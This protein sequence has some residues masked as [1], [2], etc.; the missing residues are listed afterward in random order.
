MAARGIRRGVGRLPRF[1][2]WTALIILAALVVATLA[3]RRSMVRHWAA[4]LTYIVFSLG[5]LAAGRVALGGPILALETRYLAD[6]TIPLTL[7]VGAAL[8][9]LKDEQRP[10]LPFADRVRQQWSAQQRIAG[11]L[12]A[13]GVVLVLSLHAMNSYAALSSANPY[14]PF[15]TN[16][17][18]SLREL[19]EGAEI[20]DTALPVDI[21]GPIFQEYNLVSRFI[22]PQLTQDQRTTLA[23]RREFRNP[24]YLDATGQFQPLRVDGAS[25]PAPLPGACG[26]TAVAGSATIPL[27]SSAFL[28]V[29]PFA[30]GISPTEKHQR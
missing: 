18:R 9:P 6:A 25:S 1:F 23:E 3:T 20:Y 27:G 13:L 2:D 5:I 11:G 7:V 30:S 17:E 28:G 29:G 26:W 4:P 15:V 8:M 24:F 16:V 10:W 12:I 14:R 22:A 21:V 19:P